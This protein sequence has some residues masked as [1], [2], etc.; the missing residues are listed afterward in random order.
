M[1]GTLNG[2]MEETAKGVTHRTSS[3][4]QI[5]LAAPNS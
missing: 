3:G 1:K 5:R 4:T 2:V